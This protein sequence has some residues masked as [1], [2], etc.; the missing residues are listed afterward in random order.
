MDRGT[1][2]SAPSTSGLS[3]NYCYELSTLDNV[4]LLFAFKQLP[5][6]MLAVHSPHPLGR[7]SARHGSVW[8]AITFLCGHS[9]LHDVVS[10]LCY[11]VSSLCDM[12]SPLRDV[13][14]S[15]CAVLSPLCD[16]V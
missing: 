11:V 8:K 15:L 16:V 9:L 12:V 1:K 14:L 6:E 13:V 3:V 10:P 5:H 4:A 2:M 7:E